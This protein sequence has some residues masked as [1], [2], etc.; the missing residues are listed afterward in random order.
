MSTNIRVLC[1]N[2]G[3]RWS[4]SRAKISPAKRRQPLVDAL[5]AIPGGPPGIML[6][7][8]CTEPCDRWLRKALGYHGYGNGI[9]S[10]GPNDFDRSGDN[11]AVLWDPHDYRPGSSRVKYVGV[12]ATRTFVRAIELIRRGSGDHVWAIVTHPP[13]SVVTETFR[14]K[15]VR[16]MGRWLDGEGVDLSRAVWGADWNSSRQYPERGI[17]TLLRNEFG[18]VDVTSVL[19]AEAFEG[20]STNTHHGFRATEH[21]GRHIDGIVIGR[22]VWARKGAVYRTD[23]PPQKHW[24]ADHNWVVAHL[25]IGKGAIPV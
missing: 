2:V 16:S 3:P 5:K 9:N 15:Q 8:E 22:R 13:S 6:L 12:G 19:S 17:R 11:V 23:V 25:T 4:Y 18:M 21:N 10:R 7:Q 20:N 14:M 24:P 1:A